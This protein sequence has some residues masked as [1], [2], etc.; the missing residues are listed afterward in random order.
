MPDSKRLPS[1][2]Q[3]NPQQAAQILLARQAAQLSLLEFAKLID[4]PGVPLADIDPDELDDMRWEVIETP[5]AAHH[6]LMLTTIQDLL[7]DRLVWKG[8]TVR[9]LML[10]FPPGSAK[11]TYATVVTPAWRMAKIP[12]YEVILAGHG[13]GIVKKHGKRCRQICASAQYD[14]TFNTTLDPTTKAANE[15]ALLNNSS[16]KAAGINAGITGFRCQ[17]LIWD[18]LI[19]GRE[20]A[21]SANM[22][23]KTWMAYL[24]DARSRKTP[25]AHEIGIGT[26]W[27]EDDHMGRILP[28]GYNGESGFMECRDGNVWLVLCCAAECE[29]PDDPLGREVGEMIWPEW[30]DED[31]WRDKRVNPRSWASLY[32]QRPAPDEGIYFNRGDFRRYTD[33]PKNLNKYIAFDPAV[34]GEEDNNNADSTAIQVWGV[35]D[36]GRLFLIDEWVQR[37]TMD[38]WIGQLLTMVQ[39]HKPEAVISES[40]LIRRAAEPYLRREMRQRKIFALF[41]WVTRSQD[42]PAMSRGYQAMAKAGQIYLPS[43]SIGDDVENEALRFP[44]AKDDH[45]IDAG[46]NLCLYLEKL[47]DANPPRPVKPDEGIL[48]HEIK[49]SSLMPPRFNPKRSRYSLK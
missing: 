46:T 6:E 16:Y 44:A 7:E 24:D 38:V 12:G 1:P 42:K 45:R 47:W 27:H 41:E 33:L 10:M 25:R 18:D 15:W 30:F 5:I 4:I 20:D 17:L 37:A 8:Q 28:E 29:R 22:R 43:T 26:R 11:S 9:R 40:G 32:Q 23:N 31:Y 13:D 2:R 21:D 34:T 49:I 19:K 36:T 35:D 14:N 48:S 39:M 3:P